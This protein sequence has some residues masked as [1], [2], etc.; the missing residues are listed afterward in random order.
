MNNKGFILSLLGGGKV[1]LIVGA[2]VGGWV[3]GR[4]K[5]TTEK[6]EECYKKKAEESAKRKTCDK[7]SDL[8]EDRLK[9]NIDV[10]KKKLEED[11]KKKKADA[12]KR[13]SK[14]NREKQKEKRKWKEKHKDCSRKFKESRRKRGCKNI[15]PP[16]PFEKEIKKESRWKFW[17]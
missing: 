13:V 7:A 9:F 3:L 15:E 8:D 2:L 16:Q 17:K 11:F 4:G 5:G 1:L 6:L 14:C 10:K 12:D